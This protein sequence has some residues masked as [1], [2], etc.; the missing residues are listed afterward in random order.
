MKRKDKELILILAHIE[1]KYV[2]CAS[3]EFFVET[4]KSVISY[5]IVVNTDIFNVNITG[6]NIVQEK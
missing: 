1:N 5:T 6:A 4:A 2:H 3:S